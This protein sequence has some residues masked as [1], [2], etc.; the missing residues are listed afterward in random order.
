VEVYKYVL[1]SNQERLQSVHAARK[2]RA[3]Q[4]AARDLGKAKAITEA[5]AAE[6][7]VKDTTS[8]VPENGEVQ[9]SASVAETEDGVAKG[10]E[11]EAGT[12]ADDL[13]E[14]F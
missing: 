1:E 11:V 12:K 8:V 10:D 2:K 13:V 9:G 6:E 4:K 5:E 14:A 7:G 3:A